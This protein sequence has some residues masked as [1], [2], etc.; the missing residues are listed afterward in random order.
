MGFGFFD[1]KELPKATYEGNVPKLK[2]YAA[3]CST[4][5][6]YKYCAHGQLP[7][8]GLGEKKILVITGETTRAEDDS[9]NERHGQRYAYLRKAFRLCGIDLEKDCWYTHA[10]KCYFKGKSSNKIVHACH[11]KLMTEIRELQP[12]HIVVLDQEAWETLLYDRLGGRASYASHYDWCGEVIPDQKLKT[13]IHPIY[14]PSWVMDGDEHKVNKF[15]LHWHTHIKGIL[16]VGDLPLID[17]ESKCKIFETET[18]AYAA[19]AEVKT[20]PVFAFDYETT[21]IKP[22]RKGHDIWYVSFSNGKISY[23]MPFFKTPSFR[24]AVADVLRNSATKIAHNLTF[25]M[26]WSEHILKVYVKNATQDTVLLQHCRNNKKPTGLKFL[27]YAMYGFLGYDEEM[28]EYLECSTEEKQKYGA[29]GI[30]TI[31]LAPPKKA[32]LYNA[33][34]S[35]F[36]F[37][38]YED[39]PKDIPD[40]SGYN[41]FIEGQHAL[42]ESTMNGM[43]LDEA[44]MQKQKVRLTKMVEPLYNEIMNNDLVVKQWDGGYKFSPKSDYDVRILLYKILKLE[45]VKRTDK[46]EPSVDEE[47]LEYY[48]SKHDIIPALLE[49]RRWSKALNTYIG[50]YERENNNGRLHAF[51]GLNRVATFRSGCLAEG[52]PIPVIRANEYTKK[53][54]PIEQVTKGDFVYCYDDDLNLCLRKVKKLIY[55]GIKETIRIH[56]RGYGGNKLYLDLTPEHFV[57]LSD[58]KYVRADALLQD[59]RKKDDIRRRYRP[60]AS[61]LSLHIDNVGGQDRMYITNKLTQLEHRFIYEQLHGA[62]PGGYVVHHIDGNHANNAYSNLQALTK[63]KHSLL[64]AQDT[65]KG[66]NSAKSRKKCLLAI[67][68]AHAEGRYTYRYGKDNPIFLSLTKEECIRLLVA[69]RGCPTKVPYDFQTFKN[70]CEDNGVCIEEIAL[71][72][73]GRGEYISKWKLYNTLLATGMDVPTYKKIG[74][75]YYTIHKLMELYGITYE[76]GIKN[77]TGVIKDR[78]VVLNNHVILDI[79]FTREEKPVYDLEI[80]EFH[81]FIANE[82]CVHNSNSPNLQNTPIRDKEV[83]N[84]IRVLLKAKKGHKFIEYDYK[85]NEVGGAASISGDPNLIR[86]V[87]DPSSDMHRD[88]STQLYLLPPEQVNGALRNLTKGPFVFATFY[89][90]YWE[91]TAK[92]LWDGLH[93]KDPVKTFGLDVIAHLKQKGIKTYKQWE[94]HVKE[95]ERVLWEERFPVY[96]EWRRDTFDFFCKKGYV[97]Y[98]N[99]FRYYGP[100]TKNEVLNAPVQGPS[101]HCMLWSFTKTTND[102]LDKKMN[103]CLMGQVHDSILASVDPAEEACVDRLIY[104]NGTQRVREFYPWI[105]VPL[106]IEKAAT[107]V[108]EPWSMKKTIGYLK[109]E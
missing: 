76:S 16:N 10:I 107:G 79:E 25:E 78:K 38:L 73:N 72:Y 82:I 56:Y 49:F 37:W 74:R 28:D 24:E 2:N 103:S 23:A 84:V 11:N 109:G 7:A 21:G 66:I 32:M 5:Q 106:M 90:S 9:N 94:E 22:F 17:V 15:T 12:E 62:L 75:G 89:G 96:Q 45:V 85:A 59:F 47:A 14:N 87:S 88:I 27:S 81:N 64:H 52:T 29:N 92:S 86:Y 93:V 34:D 36:T 69:A 51:Y 6:Q 99:G 26:M 102:L 19:L 40:L 31:H 30:N 43:V 83:M 67:K 35:L 3:S 46:N 80:D 97:D 44:E 13:W 100:A 68:Q 33:M 108:D 20:W 48:K 39:L 91:L 55:S 105:K 71:R 101:F 57:R 60:K 18:L 77:Q 65:T 50:Q 4:C 95:N 42:Y 98:P 1:T 104:E 63:E 41:F 8:V 70:K 53:G 61:A 54:V 58:G